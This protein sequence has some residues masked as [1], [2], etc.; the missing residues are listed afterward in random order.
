MVFFLIFQFI[1]KLVRFISFILFEESLL[2]DNYFLSYKF[3]F[4]EFFLIHLY[5]FFIFSIDEFYFWKQKKYVQ[6]I[7]LICAVLHDFFLFLFYSINLIC[8]SIFIIICL[9]KKIIL[10]NKFSKYNRVNISSFKIKYLN[11]HLSLNFSSFIFKYHWWLLFIYSH[12]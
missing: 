9:N 3:K 6:I 11:R 8:V 7:F 4:K 5:F 2:N 1:F 10:T 12:T